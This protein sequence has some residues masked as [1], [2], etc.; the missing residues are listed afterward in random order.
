MDLR[1]NYRNQM[2]TE[3][4]FLRAQ[5]YAFEALGLL[6]RDILGSGTVVG[7]LS[8][9]PTAPA[10]M[11]VNV[12]PGRIYKIEPL[13]GTD[14]GVYLGTGGIAAD[15]AADHQI[16][17]Q[18]LL[19]DTQQFAL[20][21]PV[22]VGHSIVY[23]IQATFQT[24]DD[25]AEDTTFYNSASPTVPLHEDTSQDR[26]DKCVL[27][28]KAGVSATTGTQTTP[29]ADAGYVPVWAI[30]V[31][32]GATT[33]TAPDIAQAAG[34]PVIDIGGGGGGGSGLTPWVEVPSAA[35]AVTGGRYILAQGA[36]LTLPASPAVGDEIQVIGDYVGGS[37]TVARN[38]KKI[39][40]IAG[41]AQATDLIL[42]EDNAGARLVYVG[43]ADTLWH[44][45]RGDA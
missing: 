26:R 18:G 44:V 20:T 35:A 9:T 32:Y 6:A 39:G 40:K 34:A 36:T 43:G 13:N 25:A 2:P 31:A 24:A 27:G 37:A 3:E 28:L 12:G 30:T 29:A 11:N 19:R 38:G 17:K 42:N 1:T 10:S 14:W 4:D 16:L 45:D 22:T 41:V 15:T 33:V 7:G 23:L 8:A 21:A 5:Q